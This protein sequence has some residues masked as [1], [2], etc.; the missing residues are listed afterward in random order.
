MR[1]WNSTDAICHATP[2]LVQDPQSG[3]SVTGWHAVASSCDCDAIPR[4][5]GAAS[6]PALSSRVLGSLRRSVTT[7]RVGTSVW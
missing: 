1:T 4:P 6:P 2:W 7:Y 5:A 3:E